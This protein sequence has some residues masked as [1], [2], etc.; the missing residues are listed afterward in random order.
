MATAIRAVDDVAG[1]AA[2]Q[3]SWDALVERSRTATVFSTFEWNWTAWDYRC[4]VSRPFILEVLDAGEL[5][6]LV[7]L[8]SLTEEGRTLVPIGVGY[9][10]LAEY[11]DVIAAPGYEAA[12]LEHA[13]AF[14][15]RKPGWRVLE[16]PEINESSPSYTALVGAAARAGLH[17]VMSPGS[18]CRRVEL[19]ASWP[20]YLARLSPRLREF[21]RRE[22]KLQREHDVRYERVTEEAAIEPALAAAQAMQERRWA[23]GIRSQEHD[24]FMG[25]LRSLS[26]RLLRRGWLDIQVLRVDG[27]PVGVNCDFRFR[28]RVYGYLTAF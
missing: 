27:A 26:P 19:P 4:D 13:L 14:L 21:E 12:V 24:T 7:P 10:S 2:L 6:G 9:R 23:G 1:F 17:V 3:P 18:V 25:F 20:E 16:W 28:D 8:R 11:L 22:R 5:V 15:A